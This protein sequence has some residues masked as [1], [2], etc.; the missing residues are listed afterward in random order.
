[1]AFA[2][3]APKFRTDGTAMFSL[4]RNMGQG[5]GISIVM[6]VLSNMMQV[7]HE[8]L[9]ERLTATSQAVATQMPSLLSGNPQIVSII[10]G[11]VT[12]QSAMLSYLDDF[13]LMM[14]L[15]LSAIPLILMLRG[16]KKPPANAKPK[17]QE[18][19]ALE[20]AHAMAE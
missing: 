2:T 8:E 20:R 15:S 6:A 17:T 7:N 5:V 16:P 11:L 9:G 18:E 3:I 19:V 13:W 4:V 12:Q 10:N 1:M 14:L